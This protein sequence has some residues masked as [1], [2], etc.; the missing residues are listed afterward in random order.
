M[1]RKSQSTVTKAA[2]PLAR[3]ISRA[4]AGERCLDVENSDVDTR[5]IFEGVGERV[6]LGDE[7]LHAE[8]TRS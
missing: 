8:K 2:S 7:L 4:R 6:D 1:E 5:T 3:E